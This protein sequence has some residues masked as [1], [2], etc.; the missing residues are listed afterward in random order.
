M[1]V[2]G[3]SL[4]EEVNKEKGAAWEV[5]IKI[6]HCDL[7]VLNPILLYFSV[8]NDQEILAVLFSFLQ[9]WIIK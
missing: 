7:T 6:I 3:C 1:P 4:K 9:S 2:K 8:C 5:G